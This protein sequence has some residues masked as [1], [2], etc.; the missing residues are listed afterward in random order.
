MRDGRPL[1]TRPIYI[2]G[3]PAA[4]A[5]PAIKQAAGDACDACRNAAA[6]PAAGLLGATL[7]G[8]TA[9][10]FVPKLFDWALGKVQA[11]GDDDEEEYELEVDP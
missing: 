3:P 6:T 2:S 7:L 4:D 5:V 1:I 9:A 8:V 10:Y 11:H